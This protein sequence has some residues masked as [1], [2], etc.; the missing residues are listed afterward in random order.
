[1]SPGLRSASGERIPGI[2]FTGRRFTYWSN[3]RRNLISESH[4]DTWSGAIAGQPVAPK[5]IAS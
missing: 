4:S 3:S 2:S 1:M 5:K